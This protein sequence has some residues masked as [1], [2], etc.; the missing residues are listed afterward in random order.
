MYYFVKLFGFSNLKDEE[1]QKNGVYFDGAKTLNY[2]NNLNNVILLIHIHIRY[3][4]VRI[5]E[6]VEEQNDT[7]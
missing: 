2:V 5:I 6:G 7:V 3:R 4:R 1:I